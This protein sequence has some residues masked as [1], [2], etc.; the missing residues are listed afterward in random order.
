VGTISR[1]EGNTV[2]VK[3]QDGTEVKVSTT[4]STRV[5]LTQPGKLSDLKTGT[6]VAVQG[7][8][9]ED[10]SVTAQSITTRPAP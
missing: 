6:S 4:D 2:Y 1:V 10:N 8:R 3:M 7:Q 5:E 9:A